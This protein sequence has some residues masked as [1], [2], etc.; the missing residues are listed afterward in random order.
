MEQAQAT[1]HLNSNYVANVSSRDLGNL[2]TKTLDFL[3]DRQIPGINTKINIK[4]KKKKLKKLK[5]ISALIYVY[6]NEQYMYIMQN[7]R[8]KINGI[9]KIIH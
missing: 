9:I 1:L 7:T 2:A 4:F 8:L 6:I 3:V 5:I